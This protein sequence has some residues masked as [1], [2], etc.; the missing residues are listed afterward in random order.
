MIND[1]KTQGEWKIQ[2]T[3]LI[4]FFSSKN[5]EGIRTM[6]NPSD[7]IELMVRDETDKIIE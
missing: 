5:S 1:H 6:Y 4:N 2:L 3:M 7:N